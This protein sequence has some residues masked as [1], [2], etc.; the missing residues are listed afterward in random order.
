METTLEVPVKVH[1][2][3]QL[4][5]QEEN[6]TQKELARR[7]WYWLWLNGYRNV[8]EPVLGDGESSGGKEGMR[9]SQERRENESE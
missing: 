5:R 3:D 9:T 7:S 1:E 8:K 6:R 4:G 2:L